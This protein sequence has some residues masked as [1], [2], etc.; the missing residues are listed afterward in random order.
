MLFWGAEQKKTA[1]VGEGGGAG[2]GLGTAPCSQDTG[3]LP[4]FWKES[5][6]ITDGSRDS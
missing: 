2:V 4:C 5:V 1:R 6:R 3:L